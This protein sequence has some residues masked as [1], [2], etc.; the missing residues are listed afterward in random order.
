MGASGHVR[1]AL[2]AILKISETS[3]RASW[4]VMDAFWTRYWASW[5]L[6]GTSCCLGGILGGHLG[7]LG[8]IW[9]SLGDV[10]GGLGGKLGRPGG[11][12]RHMLM[13]N[14]LVLADKMRDDENNET[15]KGTFISSGLTKR[16]L[17]RL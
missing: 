14:L 3:A 13:K 11:V 17:K 8:V 16:G 9:R 6:L 7:R 10:C 1:D 12:R 5:K 15:N 4:E 2:E